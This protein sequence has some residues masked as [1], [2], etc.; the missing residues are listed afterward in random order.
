M[1][2]KN[3]ALLV[4]SV[5][6]GLAVV[7]SGCSHAPSAPQATSA[8]SKAT[9]A[10]PVVTSTPPQEPE[11][12]ESAITTSEDP[13]PLTPEQVVESFYGWHVGYIQNVGNPMA[14]KAYRSSE[15]LTEEFVRKVDGVIASFDEGG[16]DPFLCAQDVPGEFI[17]EEAAVSGEAASVVMRE[18]WNPGT[19][20]ELTQN[21]EVSLRLVDGRW[22][23][24]DITVRM[25]PEEVVEGFYWWYIGYPG[26]P[27]VDGAYRSSEYLA[28]EFVQKVDAIAASFDQGGYD[29][30]LC[31]QDVPGEFT[32]E[33]AVV[34][35]DGASLAVHTSFEGHTFT[36]EL[37][38][39]DRR[40]KISDVICPRIETVEAG[41]EEPTASWQVFADDEHGFQ[42]RFPENWIYEERPPVPPEM[43]VPEELKALK[44][45]L[46][47]EPQG[48]NG[49]AS[50]L[51]INVTEGTEE[52]FGQIYGP[53]TST[54]ELEINGYA[55]V[56][57]IEELGEVRAIRYIFQS[58]SDETVRIVVIDSISGSPERA[59]GSED[60]VKTVRQMLSTFEFTQ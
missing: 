28:D 20:Y 7:V 55:V 1:S 19:Q 52:E 13:E 8:P 24:A 54:E 31:A 40:W 26:N 32:I 10:P 16:Y 12:P 42:V 49:T 5:T 47:F 48:W 4:L 9:S 14:D 53:A 3:F 18:T 22:K 11:E 44:Q 37:R 38:Q 6:V 50:P 45:L 36:V 58:P 15:Y 46:L 60:V 2:P 43:E 41:K 23:I 33:E 56:K 27:M 34:S 29:P 30:F 59:E 57:A 39:V 35:G 51:V 21:L 17:V 25:T